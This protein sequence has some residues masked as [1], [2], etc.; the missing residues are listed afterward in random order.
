MKKFVVTA[1]ALLATVGAAQA[2]GLGLYKGL[3]VMEAMDANC[4][5]YA[6]LA[7]KSMQ[8]VLDNYFAKSLWETMNAEQ[9]AAR[10]AGMA[11]VD[12]A[13]NYGVSKFMKQ[14]VDYKRSKEL[15]CTALIVQYSESYRHKDEK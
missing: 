14:D 4:H 11:V 2:N 15:V 8:D 13:F 1:L 7:D 10:D 3:G 12:E 6:V 9:L 5:R